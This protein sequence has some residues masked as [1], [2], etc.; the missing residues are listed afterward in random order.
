MSLQ[1]LKQFHKNYEKLNAIIPDGIEGFLSSKR[2]CYKLASSGYMDLTIEKIGK[3]TIAM[4]HWGEQNGD[5]MRDPDM[6]IRIHR[7]HKLI[8][9]LS[10]QND[11]VGVYQEVYPEP[12]K[13][14]PRLRKELNSFLGTWLSNIKNQGYS[15]KKEVAQV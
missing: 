15:L 1:Q 9:A 12:N 11:Y 14:Y 3:D 2:E 10:Y 5:L 7:E 4:T 8:E 13:V 6:S